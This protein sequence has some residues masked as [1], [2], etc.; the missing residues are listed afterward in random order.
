MNDFISSDGIF[1]TEFTIKFYV[2]DIKLEHGERGYRVNSE[3]RREIV[4][5]LRQAYLYW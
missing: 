3:V 5:Q 2:D 1:A 4:R